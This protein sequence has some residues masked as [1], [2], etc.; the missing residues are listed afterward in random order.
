ME[1]GLFPSTVCHSTNCNTSPSAIFIPVDLGWHRQSPIRCGQNVGVPL[2][3]RRQ[4]LMYALTRM[5]L[6]LRRLTLYGV[7]RFLLDSLVLKADITHFQIHWSYASAVLAPRQGKPSTS[8]LAPLPHRPAPSP[9]FLT[10]A[11]T[12]PTHIGPETSN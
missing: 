12:P 11:S 2:Q 10:L 4:Q 7:V 6:F 1:S 8:H 5:S 9:T 3:Y